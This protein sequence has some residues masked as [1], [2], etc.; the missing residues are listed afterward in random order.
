MEARLYRAFVFALYQ[1]SLVLGIA[2]MPFALAA[3]R[4]GVPVPV[5]RVVTR[6]GSAYDRAV[7]GR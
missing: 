3:R 2:L 5:H 4:V 6:L 7:D 1:L